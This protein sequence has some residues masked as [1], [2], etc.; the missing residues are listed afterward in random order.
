MCIY[1]RDERCWEDRSDL[2]LV[3]FSPPV[4]GILRGMAGETAQ[5]VLLETSEPFK[6]LEAV[7]RECFKTILLAEQLL[8]EAEAKDADCLSAVD[9]CL[10]LNALC[11]F[12]AVV[13]HGLDY[14]KASTHLF[15]SLFVAFTVPC[16]SIFHWKLYG[17]RYSAYF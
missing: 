5:Q 16:L 8:R 14:Q 1:Q 11:W 7:S 17:R 10:S 12:V 2:V 3:G 13:Y 4:L 15:L 6:D 9:F